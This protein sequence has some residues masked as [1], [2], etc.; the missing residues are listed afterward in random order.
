MGKEIDAIRHASSGPCLCDKE[1]H[2]L[3]F[4]K[5]KKEKKNH[6]QGKA[7]VKQILPESNKLSTK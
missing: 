7:L 2:I 6:M 1:V 5:E 4:E 3:L